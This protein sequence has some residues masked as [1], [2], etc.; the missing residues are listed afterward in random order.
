MCDIKIDEVSERC[1]VLV[2]ESFGATNDGARSYFGSIECSSVPP[3]IVPDRV[4]RIDCSDMN[5]KYHLII[6][7]NI[8]LAEGLSDQLNPDGLLCIP[9]IRT[10]DLNCNQDPSLAVVCDIT[11]LGSDSWMLLRKTNPNKA[12]SSWS[13]VMFTNEQGLRF[14]NALGRIESVDL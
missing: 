4:H 10:Q 5:S 12:S 8:P 7:Q 3:G 1:T 11:G 14:G 6:T 9:K 13:D 2:L